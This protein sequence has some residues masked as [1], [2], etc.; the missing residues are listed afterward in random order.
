MTGLTGEGIGLEEGSKKEISED[1]EDDI[2]RGDIGG[3]HAIGDDGLTGEGIGLHGE[4][5]SGK[6]STSPEKHLAAPPLR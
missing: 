3:L 4:S 1:E 2:R 5:K 6:R